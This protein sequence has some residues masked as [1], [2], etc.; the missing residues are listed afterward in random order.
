MNAISDTNSATQE[1][2]VPPRAASVRFSDSLVPVGTNGTFLPRRHRRRSAQARVERLRVLL[3]FPRCSW[4][5]MP[6]GA[7][8]YYSLAPVKVSMEIV[9]FCGARFLG[10]IDIGTP[11]VEREPKALFSVVQGSHDRDLLA[12]LGHRLA[13]ELCEC[14]AIALGRGRNYTRGQDQ[15]C[16]YAIDGGANLQEH[17]T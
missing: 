6:Q 2:V 1:N 10:R 15:C 7:S 13:C 8:D 14:W 12:D 11:I 5:K 17:C 3:V 16:R 9:F 4:L